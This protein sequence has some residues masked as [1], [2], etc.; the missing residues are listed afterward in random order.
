VSVFDNLEVLPLGDRRQV[1][2]LGHAER[3][4]VHGVQLL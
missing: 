4:V 2:D 3:H 1:H